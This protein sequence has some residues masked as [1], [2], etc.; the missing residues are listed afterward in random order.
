MVRSYKGFGVF[1][2]SDGLIN[3]YGDKKHDFNWQ[4]DYGDVI[5]IGIT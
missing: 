5:G 3:I 4:V 2:N 1:V